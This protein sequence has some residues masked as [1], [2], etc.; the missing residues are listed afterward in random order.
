MTTTGPL[1]DETEVG[2]LTLGELYWEELAHA[3]GGIVR[4]RATR[5][6]FALR[7]LGRG[8]DLLRFGPAE[9]TREAD[10]IRCLYAVQGGLL[11]RRASGA[12]CL[13]QSSR[14]GAELAATVTG[15]VPRWSG[16][17]YQQIQHRLH[18]AISRRYFRRLLA[19]GRA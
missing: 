13:S 14:G 8:P 10:G 5:D 2:A 17:F 19:D 18:V 7:I 11:A 4:R 1:V 15:F 9:I 12:I 6:G 3:S 16:A